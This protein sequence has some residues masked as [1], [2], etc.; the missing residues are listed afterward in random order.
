MKKEH[1]VFKGLNLVINKNESLAVVGESGSG[2]STLV[3]LI[4]RFY[5]VNHGEVLVNGVNIKNFDLTDLRLKMGLVMQEP[6]LF[7]YSIH[8]NILYGNMN[9]TNTMIKEAAQTANALEFIDSASVSNAFTDTPDALLKALE[10][11]KEEALKFME[12]AEFD[13]A[14][15]ALAD[16]KKQ[17]IADFVAIDDVLDSRPASLK[18]QQLSNGFKSNCGVKGSKLSGGQKQRIAIARA[19]VRQPSLLILDEATSALDENSQ[20][21]VQDA[22]KN[23]MQSRTSIVIAHRLTTVESCSRLVVI[24]D[25]KVVEDGVP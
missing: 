5:D 15:E 6:T 25:G 13:K 24:E 9:A 21:L 2:K 11:N 17:G 18:D 3:A 22:L 1:W 4:L 20:R 16:L 8:E 23:V 14:I 19:V 7:N 10:Q 12:Q